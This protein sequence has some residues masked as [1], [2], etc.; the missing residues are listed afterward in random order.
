MKHVRDLLSLDNKIAL[1][2]GGAGKYG[3]GIAEGLAEAG[4]IVF[5]ASAASA[6]V[7]GHNLVVDGG[8]TIW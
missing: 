7:T 3:A 1:V 8:W 6:Y 4:A 2:T 5:L